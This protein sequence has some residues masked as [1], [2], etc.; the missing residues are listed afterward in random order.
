VNGVNS[1]S[2]LATFT[3]GTLADGDI[4]TCLLTS[5]AVCASPSDVSSN[6]ET[7]VINAT[8]TPSVSITTPNQIIC[9]G[10]VIT[11]TANALNEGAAPAYQ[12]QINGL[13][14]GA[15]ANTFTSSFNDA[16]IVTCILTS[17]ALCST[18]NTAG[19]NSVSMTV[20]SIPST[21]V[22]T[23][24]GSV[25]ASSSLSGNQWYLDGNLIPGEINQTYTFTVNGTYTVVE[26]VNGCSS[27]SSSPMV[28]TNVGI[29]D[30][31]GSG[32]LYIYP[33]PGD[34]HFTV[35][36]YSLEEL[37]YSIKIENSIGQVVYTEEIG[38]FKGSYTK[39]I[40]IAEFGKGIYTL[41]LTDSKNETIK[42]IIVY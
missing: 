33:N 21:P 23:Q 17:S 9:T 20:N 7:M 18:T 40:S 1:G 24:N 29:A 27:S 19:S 4:V 5:D 10:D 31:T 42:T 22:V 3:T 32:S 30:I 28:I 36:F 6:T 37:N 39:P 11:F 16:D 26:T 25:L 41:S 13:D 2:N 35:S 14:A 8:V 38:N 34:G 15:N 12:W